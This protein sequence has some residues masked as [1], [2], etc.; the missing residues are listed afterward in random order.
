MKKI[1]A[2]Q[3][4]GAAERIVQHFQA[5]GF[6]GITEALIIQIRQ[7]GGDRAEIETAFELAFEQEKMPPVQ[8][9]FEIQPCGYFSN[10]RTFA[11][12]KTAIASDFTVSL[13]QEIPRVFF[14]A[15]PVVADDILASSTKYDVLMKLQDN[16]DGCAIAILLND[17]DASF[18]DYI[19]SHHGNDWQKIIGD[20]T[21]TTTSL[22]PEIILR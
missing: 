7:K 22:V 1:P 10:F 21:I 5:N 4:D 16:I 20:F 18:L 9:F 12:V 6:A 15:A 14:D 13:R 19:G 8:Q 11:E 2:L 3:A 17:P